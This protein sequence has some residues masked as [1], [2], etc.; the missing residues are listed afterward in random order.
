MGRLGYAAIM[1]R[2]LD[3]STGAG[4]PV[5]LLHSESAE[6]LERRFRGIVM[7]SKKR[8]YRRVLP[9]S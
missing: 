5:E 1:G 4:H 3:N 6:S 2:D 9:T 7:S 8:L